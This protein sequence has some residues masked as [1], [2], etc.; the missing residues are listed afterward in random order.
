MTT[1]WPNN[2]DKTVQAALRY[3]AKNDRP[4]GG[5]QHYNAMHLE[6]LAEEIEQAAAS[7]RPSIDDRLLINKW[8]ILDRLTTLSGMARM[9]ADGH[10][11]D[12]DRDLFNK[13]ER[14]IESASREFTTEIQIRMKEYGL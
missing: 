7:V 1:K 5:E 3:L 4:I 10:Y 8:T 6:Q 9:F 11:T 14:A 2:F 13:L 12:V